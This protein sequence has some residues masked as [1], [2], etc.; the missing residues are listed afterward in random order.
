MHVN[1]LFYIM[2]NY[3]KIDHNLVKPDAVPHGEQNFSSCLKITSN[4][5]LNL[6]K[7]IDAN[8]A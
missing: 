5:A 2:E 8:G 3:P 4:D 7:E 6:L 1:D